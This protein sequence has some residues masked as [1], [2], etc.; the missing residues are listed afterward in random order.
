MKFKYR[1][2]IL[3]AADIDTEAAFWAGLLDGRVDAASDRWRNVWI[4]GDWQL[5]IQLADDHVPPTWP[6]D[7]V[8]QQLHFDLYVVGIDAVDAA[9]QKVIELGGRVLKPAPDRTAAK[10]FQVHASPAGHPFCVCWIPPDPEDR[11]P[12]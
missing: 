2:T 1:M 12:G 6:D 7:G 8:P 4:D 11:N 10:G 3:N 9:G 5:G